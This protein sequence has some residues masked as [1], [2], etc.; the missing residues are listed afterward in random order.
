[1]IK[2][3]IN[4][5]I[6]HIKTA[7]DMANNNQ[8]KLTNTIL[9][10]QGFS[11]IKTRHLYNNLCNLSD[12]QYLEIG[13]YKGSTLISSLYLNNTTHGIAVDNWSEFDGSYQICQNNLELFISENQ[14]NLIQKDS[15]SLTSNDIPVNTVDIY[16]YDGNH[17]YESQYKAIVDFEKFLSPISI[18]L[19]DDFR[20]DGSWKQVVDGTYDGFRDS[21]L[22]IVYHT[23]TASQQENNGATDYWN[24]CGIFLCQKQ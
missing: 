20:E 23:R 3:T 19:I 6:E 2:K 5:T 18:V 7:L 11:G 15:F 16:L 8:S 21:N 13:T 17:T 22:K 1:M 9:R 12:I 10:L 4:D 24:G 14:Y